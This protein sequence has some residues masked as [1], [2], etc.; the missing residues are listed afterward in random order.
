M[1]LGKDNG[2]QLRAN[3]TTIDITTAGASAATDFVAIAS[4]VDAIWQALITL[5][6]ISWTVAPYDG[7]AALKVAFGAMLSDNPTLANSV[8]STNLKAD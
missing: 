3:G 4:K 6:T 8:A 7:G 5:F 2:T 1:A